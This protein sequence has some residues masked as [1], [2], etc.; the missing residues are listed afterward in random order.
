MKLTTY[1]RA[2]LL[3]IYLFALADNGAVAEVMK[4]SAIGKAGRVLSMTRMSPG[5]DPKHE[6]SLIRR[7]YTDTC[8][9]P[10]FG[11]LQ[12]E[13]INFSD[14]FLGGTG[15]QMGYRVA[16]HSSGDQIFCAY[17]GKTQV[18]RGQDKKVK[19]SFSG[20][21]WFIGGTG[22]FKGITGGGTYTGSSTTEGVVYE[23]EGSYEIPDEPSKSLK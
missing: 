23:W 1:I 5:D 16:S 19:Y 7:V 22:R 3:G 9:N 4:I 2:C 10:A 11:T 12:V 8:S 14:Y 20:K 13:T 21:W 6:V 17:E 15:M 18:E